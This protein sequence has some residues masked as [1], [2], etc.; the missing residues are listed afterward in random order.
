MALVRREF[1]LE[2]T[3]VREEFERLLPVAVGSMQGGVEGGRA[4]GAS[5]GLAWSLHVLEGRD[6][7]LGQLTLPTLY[8]TLECEAAH[9][10]R[11]G[12]FVERFL[13]AYRRAGG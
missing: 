2:M 13:L 11:I 5:S 6:R 3:L 10:D 8:V 9:A 7:R 4:C 12:E 1:R